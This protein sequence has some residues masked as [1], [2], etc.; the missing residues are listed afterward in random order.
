M[1]DKL[2][3]QDA[4]L[5]NLPISSEHEHVDH[6]IRAS[7]L[8]IQSFSHLLGSFFANHVGTP[9]AA[10]RLNDQLF[11]FISETI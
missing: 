4:T 1:P 8:N 10:Y 6:L 7:Q 3:I 2:M 9:R 5:K 11:H